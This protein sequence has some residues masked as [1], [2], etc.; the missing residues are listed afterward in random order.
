[1][2]QVKERILIVNEEK[3]I[4]A[5]FEATLKNNGFD[6]DYFRNPAVALEK[7]Q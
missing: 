2:P 1:M 7:Q 5:T 4:R 3:N 6:T